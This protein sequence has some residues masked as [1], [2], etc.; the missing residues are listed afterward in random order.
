MKPI[1]LHFLG[2]PVAKG[3]ARFTRKGR[4]PYTP[5]RTRLW[6]NRAKDIAKKKMQDRPPLTGAIRL[7]LYIV[8]KP[9]QSWPV[10]KKDY[11]LKGLITHTIKP[12]ADNVQKIVKDS[13]NGIVYHDDAQVYWGEFK[14]TFGPD[15]MV[16][17]KVTEMLPAPCTLKSKKEVDAYL[18]SRGVTV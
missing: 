10:W 2:N 17:A 11:A 4:S 7:D 15:P 14:K 9:S 6:E 8:F 3:R 12:D 13:M 1:V 18:R 16:I 5:A